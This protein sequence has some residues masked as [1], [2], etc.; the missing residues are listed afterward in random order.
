MFI[1]PKQMAVIRGVLL[2]YYSQLDTEDGGG[3]L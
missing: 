1:K 2:H 3:C